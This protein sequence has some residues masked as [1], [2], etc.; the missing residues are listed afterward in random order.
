LPL[1]YEW[2]LDPES[3][4]LA[5]TNP[6]QRE[7]FDA[8]WAKILADPSTINRAILLGETLVGSISCYSA[9]GEDFVG[10][11]I[12]RAHWG[13]GIATSALRLFLQ[14]VTRRPLVA[15]AAAGNTASLRVLEK[16]CFVL[17]EKRFSP[18]S[19][20]Y[21]ACEEAIHLLR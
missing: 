20:R 12:D 1:L 14:E 4:R 21:P 19:E 10:Y 6:R 18:A 3:N 13:R 7:A 16:C 5:V 2:Q 15:I 17:Q 8:H 9:D 11:W